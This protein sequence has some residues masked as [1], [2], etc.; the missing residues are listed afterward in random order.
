MLGVVC[1]DGVFWIHYAGAKQFF[2]NL[3]AWAKYVEANP[4]YKGLPSSL[5]FRSC[6]QATEGAA[7]YCRVYEFEADGVRAAIPMIVNTW[8]V[9]QRNDPSSVADPSWNIREFSV[10]HMASCGAIKLSLNHLALGVMD[11]TIVSSHYF[12]NF[13]EGIDFTA[14]LHEAAELR[15]VFS[16]LNVEP[17]ALMQDLE[18]SLTKGNA[19]ALEPNLVIMCEKEAQEFYA[20]LKELTG[21]RQEASALEFLITLLNDPSHELVE[22][23]SR[24]RIPPGQLADRAKQSLAKRHALVIDHEPTKGT[25]F[26]VGA[27]RPRVDLS[28]APVQAGNSTLGDKQKQT[29]WWQFWG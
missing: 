26:P 22:A 5:S 12:Q 1:P 6:I 8:N 24:L 21:N 4:D 14:A 16:A 25:T 29:R 19:Y 11:F 10:Q 2:Q 13:P 20:H 23:L 15:E 18:L 27:N 9:F 17:L 7:S 28:H 3:F